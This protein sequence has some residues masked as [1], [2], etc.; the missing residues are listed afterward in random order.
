MIPQSAN[1]SYQ[2]STW[3]VFIG[4][5]RNRGQRYEKKKTLEHIQDN[6]NYMVYSRL[7][8]FVSLGI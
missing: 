1:I 6:T 4:A 8:L 3:I 5:T 7:Q 2:K